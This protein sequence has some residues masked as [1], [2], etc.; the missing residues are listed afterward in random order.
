MLELMGSKKVCR[1]ILEVVN[2]AAAHKFTVF[3]IQASCF[4]TFGNRYL[5]WTKLLLIIKALHYFTLSKVQGL[6]YTGRKFILIMADIDHAGTEMSTIAVNQ[7][8]RKGCL[9]PVQSLTGFVQDQQGWCF[10]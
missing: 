8:K 6:V 10:D 1:R 5:F 2:G 9:R 3:P 7:M 4:Y